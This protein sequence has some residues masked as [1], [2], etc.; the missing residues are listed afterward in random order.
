M[1]TEI[2]R[3][4]GMTENEIKIY[5]E[6][7]KLGSSSATS[8]SKLSGVNRSKVYEVIKKLSSKGLVH[9]V[10]QENKTTF[11]ANPPEEILNIIKDEKEKLTEK[12]STL[13]NVIPYLKSIQKTE[14]EQQ[15]ANV[16][17]GLKGIKAFHNKILN[18][19]KPNTEICILGVPK[20]ANELLEGYFIEF[21]KNRIK[22][23]IRIKILYSYEAKEKVGERK[24]L[25]LTEAK[26]LGKEIKT[27]AVIWVYNG[28][29]AIFDFD[30]KPV[31]YELINSEIYT[32]FLSYFE[33]LWRLAKK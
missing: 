20:I 5:L 18:K 19:A 15:K 2:L 33:F 25:S 9:S 1:E 27:P 14:I 26:Y 11:S 8:L 21:H 30:K 22:K 31:C 3:K 16:Y 6:L 24:N 10:I 4:I 12:E 17:E 28:L 7:I 32:S 29:I 13:K 23:K